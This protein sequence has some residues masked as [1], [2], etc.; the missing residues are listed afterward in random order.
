MSE[1]V[2]QIEKL[3]KLIDRLDKTWYPDEDKGKVI[4]KIQKWYDGEENQHLIQTIDDLKPIPELLSGPYAEESVIVARQ[5]ALNH[6]RSYSYKVYKHTSPDS[7]IY[8]GMTCQDL[9]FRWQSGYGYKNNALFFKDIS[10]YG[11]DAFTHEILYEG[12]TEEEA[13]R[14]EMELISS[15][16]SDDPEHGYNLDKGGKIPNLVPKVWNYDYSRQYRG[17]RSVMKILVPDEQLSSCFGMIDKWGNQLI[18]SVEV[19]SNYFPDHSIV[20]VRRNPE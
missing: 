9:E 14:R 5:L 7:K 20:Y 6:V 13:C 2:P 10:D 15:C 4:K 19:G 18:K 16:M 17:R 1:I 8:I 12:L 3:V 11:W